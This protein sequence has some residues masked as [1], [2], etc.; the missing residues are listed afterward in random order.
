VRETFIV[1]IGGVL[2]GEVMAESDIDTVVAW[3]STYLKAVEMWGL[4]AE[5]SL[6]EHS[7]FEQHAR[8][9]F[10]EESQLNDSCTM[11]YVCKALSAVHTGGKPCACLSPRPVSLAHRLRS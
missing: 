10:L 8:A 4:T 7:E 2:H 6:L 11:G 9:D 3:V 1:L 5:P